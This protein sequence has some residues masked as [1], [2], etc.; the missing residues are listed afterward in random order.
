MTDLALT[1]GRRSRS[2]AARTF[3]LRWLAR[4]TDE[5]RRAQHALERKDLHAREQNLFDR[6]PREA[7]VVAEPTL[8]VVHLERQGRRSERVHMPDDPRQT[9]GRTMDQRLRPALRE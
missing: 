1:L 7:V 5:P 9:S 4:R 6:H 2:A 3:A 8:L